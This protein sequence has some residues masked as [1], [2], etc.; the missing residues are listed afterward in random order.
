MLPPV[1]EKYKSR[2]VSWSAWQLITEKL[3]IPFRHAIFRSAH[4]PWPKEKT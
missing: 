2:H 1:S 4:G 3:S